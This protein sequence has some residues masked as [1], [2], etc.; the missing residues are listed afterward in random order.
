MSLDNFPVQYSPFDCN[1][2]VSLLNYADTSLSF[3]EGTVAEIGTGYQSFFSI[4]NPSCVPSV[5]EIK[6]VGC[7]GSYQGQYS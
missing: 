4:L 7:T 2:E 5:C 6:D 1:P 3:M